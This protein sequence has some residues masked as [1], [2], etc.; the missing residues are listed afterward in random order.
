MVGGGTD[1]I[2]TTLYWNLAL[3]CKYPEVQETAA[4]E[5]DKYTKN[6]NGT[7]PAFKD[8]LHLPYCVAVIKECMR[9]KPTT[10]F[11]LPHANREAGT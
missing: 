11:G 5:I 2:S 8:R 7:L 4:N 6:N 10:A 9:F 1:T 3:M